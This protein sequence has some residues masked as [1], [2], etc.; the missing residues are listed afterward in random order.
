MNVVSDFLNLVRYKNLLIIILTQ[1]IIKYVLINPHISSYNLNNFNFSLLVISTILIAGAGNIVND[2]FDI[3]IDQFNQRKIIIGETIKRRI[4]IILHLLFSIV[5]I[6]IGFYLSY[7]IELTFLGFIN[8]FCVVSLWFYSTTF[9]RKPVVGNLL[10]AFLS[11]LVLIVIPL[12][13]LLP[14]LNEESL[15]VITKVSFYVFF[16]FFFSFIREIIK[17]LED[18]D[19]DLKAG[20]KTFAI[21]LGIKRTKK[22]LKI[23][24]VFMLF[25]FLYLITLFYPSDYFTF[26]YLLLLVTTPLF[27]FFILLFKSETKKEFSILSM[28]LKLIM[29]SGI[30]SMFII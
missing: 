27:I 25:V 28:L 5:G 29:L 26:F 9:K 6:I 10:I 16:A 13:D 2:Y 23:L 17:D 15:A 30:F 19:G 1:F 18:I 14:I 12:Y 3:K 11:A 21:T 4:A 7:K 22:V 24:T 20:L 8:L